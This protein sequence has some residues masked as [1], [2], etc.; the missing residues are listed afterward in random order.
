MNKKI[1]RS[2]NTT[3]KA[4]KQTYRINKDRA[5]STGLIDTLQKKVD[6]IEIKA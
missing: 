3:D 6:R 2:R 4:D 5:E 1:H